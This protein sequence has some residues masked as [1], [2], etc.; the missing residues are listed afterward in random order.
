M[1]SLLVLMYLVAAQSAFARQYI[2]C[3]SHNSWDR[4]V[5]NLDGEK[6]TLF[7]TNGVHLP[8]EDQLRVLKSLYYTSADESFTYYETRDGQILEKVQIPNE[9]I[10]QYSDYFEVV[11]T[12]TMVSSG[13]SQDQSLSCY[14]AIYED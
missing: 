4:S 10:G 9:V 12:L 2:Q 11:M 6:S 3:A 14:S 5:I 8:P 1:K 7:L 13:Y